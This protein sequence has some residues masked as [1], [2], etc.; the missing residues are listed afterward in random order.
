MDCM[1]CPTICSN[2]TS[3]LGNTVR[4]P[5]AKNV[6]HL[7]REPPPSHQP[8]KL[9]QGA[10]TAHAPKCKLHNSKHI[11]LSLTHVLF[12]LLFKSSSQSLSIRCVQQRQGLATP[13][14]G[15]RP[16]PEQNVCWRQRKP[17]PRIQA[18]RPT[19]FMAFHN[20]IVV[21]GVG[22]FW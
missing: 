16:Q 17:K 21:E 2:S 10:G 14:S 18:H 8:P 20:I 4:I 22:R 19:I 9:T 11:F 6:T 13:P 5:W 3:R 1:A 7:C 15:P 12:H